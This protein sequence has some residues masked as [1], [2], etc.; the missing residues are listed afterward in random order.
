LASS[1]TQD[2]RIAE[3]DVKW[4]RLTFAPSAVSRIDYW[5]KYIKEKISLIDPN[6]RQ[7]DLVEKLQIPDLGYFN[8]NEHEYEATGMVDGK[9]PTKAFLI[10]YGNGDESLEEADLPPFH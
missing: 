5:I 9:T 4:F 10:E 6:K 2:R 7:R 1:L 8:T 3:E